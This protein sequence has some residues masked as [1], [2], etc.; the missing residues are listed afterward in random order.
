MTVFDIDTERN[1][2]IGKNVF[3][4][5]FISRWIFLEKKSFFWTQKTELIINSN[6]IGCILMIYLS[7]G[8]DSTLLNNSTFCF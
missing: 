5:Q 6:E 2:F 7:I 4:P 3:A 1:S 8:V